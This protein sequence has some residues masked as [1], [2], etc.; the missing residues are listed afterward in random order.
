MLIA[1]AGTAN[2]V[3]VVLS[4]NVF[5]GAL[6]ALALAAAAAPEVL[7][8]P[9]RREPVFAQ[10]LMASVQD[11]AVCR[12]VRFVSELTPEPGDVIHLYGSN[13]TIV[14]ICAHL[15][16]DVLVR[17]HGSGL[18]VAV[19]GADADLSLAAA[20]LAADMV[21]FDQHGCLSPRVALVAAGRGAAL[22]RA[23]GQA[24]EGWNQRVAPG[25][26]EREELGERTRYRDI[27][28]AVGE[29]VAAGESVIGIAQAWGPPIVPPPGRNLHIVQ[30]DDAQAAQRWIEPIARHVAAIGV[31]G[32]AEDETVASVVRRLPKARLSW[33]GAMQRPPFDGPVDQRYGVALAPRH[34]RQLLE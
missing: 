18:G 7:V 6:R 4:S 23:V 32:S 1:S 19:I 12:S 29:V 34:V 11:H 26:F 5:V 33:L 14:G 17:A 31:A 10:A 3:Q 28:A 9:S 27:V 8:R 30:C 16:D 2:R 21:P 24:L 13:Q 15:P 22:G 20:A 25:R